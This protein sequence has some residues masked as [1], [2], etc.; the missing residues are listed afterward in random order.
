M[1]KYSCF[2][3]LARRAQSWVL[4][5]LYHWEVLFHS[6]L[7]SEAMKKSQSVIVHVCFIAGNS[8]PQPVVSTECVAL[9]HFEHF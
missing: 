7:L 6:L 1:Y 8:L 5:A 4:I 2:P 9:D 3:S